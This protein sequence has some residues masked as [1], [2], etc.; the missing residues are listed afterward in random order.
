M[1]VKG[2]QFTI[3]FISSIRHIVLDSR[4]DFLFT[5]SLCKSVGQCLLPTECLANRAGSKE[6]CLLVIVEISM[7]LSIVLSFSSFLI[8]PSSPYAYTQVLSFSLLSPI[9]ELIEH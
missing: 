9:M 1:K 6:N 5:K 8:H 7:P 4:K 3:R 2:R